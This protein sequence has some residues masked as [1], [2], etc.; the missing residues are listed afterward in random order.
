[1]IQKATNALYRIDQLKLTTHSEAWASSICSPTEC[2]H[3][4]VTGAY[5]QVGLC[6]ACQLQET[7]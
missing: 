2:I 4:T 6:V 5:R 3:P 7:R 1:M